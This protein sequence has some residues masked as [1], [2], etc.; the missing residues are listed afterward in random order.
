MKNVLLTG[1]ALSLLF[2][3]C[4]KRNRAERVARESAEMTE[5][6]AS[7]SPSGSASSGN[8]LTHT[9]QSGDTYVSIA[10]LYD[11]SVAELLTWNKITYKTP[12]QP[13]QRL[14]VDPNI[15][16]NKA[17]AAVTTA[18]PT[19]KSLAT[20]TVQPGETLFRI[21]QQYD[22]RIEDLRALNNLKSDAIQVGQVL[23]I[24]P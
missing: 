7:S 18:R 10:R 11:I 5:A 13:G 2:T 16:Q 14:V 22:V 6:A 15:S 23:K 8:V 12:I 1:L 21:S 3:S 4:A 24:K 9:V 20:H 19:G 17:G